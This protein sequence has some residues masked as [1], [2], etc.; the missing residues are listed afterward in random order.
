MSSRWVVARRFLATVLAVVISVPVALTGCVPASSDDEISASLRGELADLP[1]VLDSFVQLAYDGPSER[2]VLVRLYLDDVTG[3]VVAA[4]I[5]RALAVGWETMP[6]R[7]SSI[8]VAVVDGPPPAQPSSLD[9]DGLDLTGASQAL[10]LHLVASWPSLLIV[11]AAVLQDRFGA[12][13][14]PAPR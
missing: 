9:R 8:T 5:D 7:P 1:H 12:W 10:G 6:S 14:G 4:S 11:S 3:E 13:T 2:T